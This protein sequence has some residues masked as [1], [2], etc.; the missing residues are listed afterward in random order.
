MSCAT[1][2]KAAD[3][4]REA[5]EPF[6]TAI[7]TGVELQEESI[8]Y[9][10]D[11]LREFGAEQGWQK[12]TLDLLNRTL[13]AR[14]RTIDESLRLTRRN[15]QRALAML[16]KAMDGH[17]PQNEPA[18][19]ETGDGVWSLALGALRS[20]AQVMLQANGRVIELWTDLAKE[21]S[22]QVETYQAEVQAAAQQARDQK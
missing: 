18:A 14:Q 17:Q 3:F 15:A 20:N 19:E 6:Q 12:K 5:M 22:K 21:V 4:L 11:V 13:Q 2:A 7:K 10:T 1:E 9:C 8:K 16:Q